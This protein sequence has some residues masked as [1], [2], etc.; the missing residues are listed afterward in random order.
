[1]PCAYST[2]ELRQIINLIWQDRLD[3]SGA[4]SEKTYLG[5]VNDVFE[6]FRKKINNPIRILVSPEKKR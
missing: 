5:R 6:R 2:A 1:M 4:V 3:I